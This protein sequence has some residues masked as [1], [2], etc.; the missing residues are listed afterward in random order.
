MAFY[1]KRAFADDPGVHVFQNL[2]LEADGDASQ[3]DHLILHGSRAIV[4]ESKSATSSV[5]INERDEWK[6]EWNGR[7]TDM[8]SPVLQTRRQGDFMRKVL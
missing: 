2:R 8:P 1:L 4:I 5:R 7:S 6:K 3:I